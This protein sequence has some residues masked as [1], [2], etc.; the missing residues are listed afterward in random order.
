MLKHAPTFAIGGVET[1]EKEP[2]KEC[3]IPLISC[4]H[5][6]PDSANPR[7]RKRTP[8]NVTFAY[9]ARTRLAAGSRAACQ[10]LRGAMDPGLLGSPHA[11]GPRPS[12]RTGFHRGDLVTLERC[13]GVATLSTKKLQ[14]ADWHSYHR[15]ETQEPRKTRARG[16]AQTLRGCFKH[17]PVAVVRPRTKSSN[18]RAQQ[19]R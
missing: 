14:L 5:S 1:A 9:A 8:E 4:F 6:C 7:D 17:M 12:E 11:L 13:T 3:S 2:L 15:H 10:G 16:A 19:R 18:E